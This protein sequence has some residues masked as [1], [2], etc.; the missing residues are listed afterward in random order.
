MAILIG[1]V[2]RA[3]LDQYTGPGESA[4]PVVENDD[5]RSTALIR[6]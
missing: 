5:A 4:L 6:P 1:S 2:V 3:A